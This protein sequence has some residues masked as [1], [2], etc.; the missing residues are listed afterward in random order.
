MI[1]YVVIR[2]LLVLGILLMTPAAGAEESRSCSCED[3]SEVCPIKHTVKHGP[4]GLNIHQYLDNRSRIQVDHDLE[5][6]ILSYGKIEQKHYI[7]SLHVKSLHEKAR[8]RNAILVLI[9]LGS[10]LSGSVAGLLVGYY[11]MK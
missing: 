6:Y 1:R 3:K 9:I 8:A 4:Y 11:G 10:V 2:L 5:Y 7:Q